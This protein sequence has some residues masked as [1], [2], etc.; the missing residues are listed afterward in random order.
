M[1]TG[2]HE[3]LAQSA[4]AAIEATADTVRAPNLLD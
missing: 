2:Q 3:T 1:F 4:N